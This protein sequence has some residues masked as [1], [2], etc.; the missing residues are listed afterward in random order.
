MRLRS[1]NIAQ[2]RESALCILRAWPAFLDW[3]TGKDSERSYPRGKRFP[4]GYR[5][6]LLFSQKALPS[7]RLWY[8]SSF[9][10]YRRRRRTLEGGTSKL[11]LFQTFLLWEELSS[12]FKSKHFT[13][14]SDRLS[15]KPPPLFGS[16][17][18]WKEKIGAFQM[19][20]TQADIY[21]VSRLTVHPWLADPIFI[22]LWILPHNW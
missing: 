22:W 18:E 19:D 9:Q 8:A 7:Q 3:G 15:E 11:A 12:P 13:E 6:I 14:W 5:D 2:L 10:I 17:S 16:A 1:V 21:L 20:A 4:L